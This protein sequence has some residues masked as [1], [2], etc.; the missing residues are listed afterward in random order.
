MTASGLTQQRLHALALVMWDC[1]LCAVES[2]HD[3]LRDCVDLMGVGIGLPRG[4]TVAE[5]GTAVVRDTAKDIGDVR[6]ACSLPCLL[7]YWLSSM[8]AHVDHL[9]CGQHCLRRDSS[10]HTYCHASAE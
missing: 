5:E 4:D 3:K 8:F 1:L 9:G 10:R 2:L 7:A 6:W